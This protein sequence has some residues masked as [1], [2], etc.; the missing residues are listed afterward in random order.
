MRHSL[1][2]MYDN[3]GS[4]KKLAIDYPK[5]MV[6][7]TG[8]QENKLFRIKDLNLCAVGLVMI[9]KR[10]VQLEYWKQEQMFDQAIAYL[11]TKIEVP[12]RHSFRLKIEN[13]NTTNPHIDLRYP[14]NLIIPKDK[15]GTKQFMIKDINLCVIAIIAIIQKG[16]AD[17]IW[18]GEKMFDSVMAYMRS[19]LKSGTSQNVTSDLASIADKWSLD[20]Q[21]L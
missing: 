5:Y 16:E 14:P 13:T 15:E 17:G 20:Q 1:I 3:T 4:E 6:L 21:E 8:P 12:M 19:E 18:S 2:L 11:M 9:I 10:G 7:P